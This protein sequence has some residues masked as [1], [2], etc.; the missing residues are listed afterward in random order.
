MVFA[1]LGVA[2]LLAPESHSRELDKSKRRACL[3][4]KPKTGRSCVLKTHA[5]LHSSDRTRHSL[6]P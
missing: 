4:G 1:C 2:D 6:L 5:S 3:G